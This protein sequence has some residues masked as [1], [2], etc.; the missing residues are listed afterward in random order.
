[1]TRKKDQE[2]KRTD[3][4]HTEHTLRGDAA[5][6][7]ALS[8]RK[9]PDLNGQKAEDLIH[10]LQVHQI[11]LE[12]QAEELRR[13]HLT[14]EESRDRYMDLYDFAPLGYLTLSDKGL[15][16]EANLTGA[17]LLAQV[18]NNLLRS[19]FSKFVAD[20]DSDQ[21]HRYFMGVMGQN[22]RRTCTLAL[23]RGDG[24]EFPARLEA[25]R[26]TEPGEGGTAVRVAISDISDLKL[27]EN[28]LRESEARYRAIMDQAADVIIVNDQKGRIIDV[29]QKA[30]R[31]LGYSRE[32]LLSRS[33]QDIDPETIKTG[34]HL[35]IWDG[36]I[37]GSSFT[38]ES[39]HR[40]RDGSTFPVEETLGPVRLPTGQAI[41]GI[42]RD[43]TERKRDESYHETG[44]KILQLLNEPATMQEMLH[45]VLNTFKA[46]IGVDAVG[47]RLHNKEDFPYFS[48]IGFS[49]DFLMKEN[50]LLSQNKE[51]G[52]CRGANGQPSLDCTCGLVIS[53]RTDPSNPLFTNGGS[54]W[55]NDSSTL[56]D[57]T[58]SEDPRSHPR[59]TCIHQGYASIA[60]VPIRGDGQIVGLLQ[61]NS[62]KKGFFSQEGVE[63]LELI[64]ENIG[65]AILRKKAEDALS[66]SENRYHVLV[67]S[68]DEGIVVEQD[69]MLRFVNPA[70]VALTGFPEE[71]LK[72]VPFITFIDPEDRSMVEERHHK[73][74]RGE[75]DL[76]RS[77]FRLTT[78]NGSTRWVEMNAIAIEWE[79]KPATLNFL[80]DVTERLT[81]EED[82]K[83]SNTELQQFAF[84]ASH[85]LQEPLRM[86]VSYLTLL[87][88]KY[89]N[90]LDPEA[91]E[92]IHYAVDGGERMRHL[93]DDLLEYSRVDTKGKEFDLVDMNEAVKSTLDD[94]AVLI[95]ENRAEII[96]DILPTVVADRSQVVRVFQNLIGN[97]LKF[98]GTEP[99]R[100]HVSAKQGAREWT[101]EVKDNGIGFDMQYADKI[102][103]MFQRLHTRAE[104]QG[105]GIGLAIVKKIVERH[106]GQ[107]WAESEEGKG[108]SFF[109]TIPRE[110]VKRTPE[111]PTN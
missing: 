29:N 56:L 42:V 82:I 26:M 14:L 89:Q 107:I 17:T 32:E 93:I 76:L 10:E 103:M 70:T 106:G 3:A 57:L 5:E 98:R 43:I 25:I 23:R 12:M 72:S 18:R 22:E 71:K 24:S 36:V 28:A 9:S 15:I 21:W 54:A 4:P 99:P 40:R 62:H 95:E 33:I 64:A 58:S 108:T 1:M 84:V 101:F 77:V 67:D 86:V 44:R 61:F 20:R 52:Y 53:G 109:F 69:G 48:H 16:I 85:D 31:S 104:Y 111:H 45:R 66:A 90:E 78:A 110:K 38:F 80:K 65:M 63:S 100:I 94:L 88:K 50:S 87:E 13:A 73:R 102:F 91:Q 2:G 68:A 34:I 75:S 79:E 96:V 30:C 27:M 37:A 83:R 49:K 51:G 59:N 74:S 19:R 35:K 39:R 47:I 8:P 55:T 6:Q 60:L 41:L 81:A 105:T 92:F 7:L 46:S 97:A 11:E